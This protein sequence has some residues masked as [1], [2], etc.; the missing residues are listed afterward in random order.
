MSLML[1]SP[2]LV[3]ALLVGV[4]ISILQTITQVQE[5]TLTFVPKI[6][7]TLGVLVF[8]SPWLVAQ[9]VDYTQKTFEQLVWMAQ[10]K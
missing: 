5:A 8:L 7:V 1:A 10:N 3:V 6:L 4:L 9:T 2:L